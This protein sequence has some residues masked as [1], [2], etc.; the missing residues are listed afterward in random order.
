[1]AITSVSKF[2]SSV[3]DGCDARGVTAAVLSLE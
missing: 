3:D 1:M 2:G